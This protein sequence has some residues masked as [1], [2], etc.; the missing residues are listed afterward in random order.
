M[1]HRH[2]VLSTTTFSVVVAVA[3]VA[4]ST[5]P[6]GAARPATPPSVA[7]RPVCGPA[8]LG[9][10]RCDARVVVDASGAPLVTATPSGF[11]PADLKAAYNLPA[12]TATPTVAIVDAYDDPSA[13]ADLSVYR[14][15][16]GIPQCT[17]ANG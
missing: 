11:G 1:R 5:A 13:E 2:R 15:Q 12:S 8:P 16:Y 10:A 4:L 14:A 3:V 9:S 6:A 7:N 17:T